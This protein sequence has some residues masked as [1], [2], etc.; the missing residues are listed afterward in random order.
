MRPFLH[1]CAALGVVVSLA[2]CSEA[3]LIRRSGLIPAPV[4][5]THTG[6]ALEKGEVELSGG[7][8][9]V[10]MGSLD[11]GAGLF[12][13]TTGIA[14]DPGVLIPTVQLALNARVGLTRAIEFGAF[15][16]YAAHAWTEPNVSGVLPFPA[17]NAPDV[18]AGGI[19]ARVNIPVG[20]DR[21][22][23]GIIGDLVMTQVHEAIFLCTNTAICT[24]NE[25]V[26][27]V[28]AA[29]I[30]AFQR[31]DTEFF[32]LPQLGLHLGFAPIP[33]LM[34]WLALGF[35]TSVTNTGFDNR[36]STLPD[37]SLETYMMGYAAFGLDARVEQLVLGASV[38]LPFG[39]DS[40]IDFPALFGLRIGGR[41]GGPAKADN[42]PAPL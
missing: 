13:T 31:I 23:F 21:F 7:V 6:F 3:T 42:E 30:Y 16:R 17:N 27:D 5:P 14:G 34:P 15:V 38:M 24:G 9:S 4:T 39:D 29:D 2:A 41:F 28:T 40:G 37:D 19:S 22:H 12:F 33:E 36:L 10:A 26:S 18:W 8:D 11:R 1:A 20:D 25:L 32:M 35:T